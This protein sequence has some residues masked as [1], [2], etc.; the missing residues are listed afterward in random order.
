MWLRIRWKS[1]WKEPLLWRRL[2][3]PLNFCLTVIS[4]VNKQNWS[5]S[6]LPPITSPGFML[7]NNSIVH[8]LNHRL[9]I[10]QCS[11]ILNLSSFWC[12]K[13]TLCVYILCIFDT[14]V[15]NSSKTMF[16]TEQTCR[17]T[18]SVRHEMRLP[19]DVHIMMVWMYDLG[20]EINWQSISA[21]N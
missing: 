8:L 6:Y 21:L 18:N 11:N 4:L 15:V 9:F 1:N 13:H 2:A 17:V 10:E 3:R 14:Y 20:N 19:H 5:F 16:R 12:K 7:I